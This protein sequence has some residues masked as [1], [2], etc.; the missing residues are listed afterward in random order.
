MKIYLDDVREAPLGWVLV[1]KPVTVINMMLKHDVTHLSLD[2]DLG[3]DEGRGT[4][5]D[6]LTF[7]EDVIMTGSWERRIPYITVHSMNPVAR[8]RM[9]PLANKL[10]EMIKDE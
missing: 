3:D 4:G 6:V 9:I 10:N 8:E 7:L 2:H 1:E 5:Y